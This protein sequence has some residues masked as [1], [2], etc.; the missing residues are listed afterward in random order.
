MQGPRNNY[1]RLPWVI[2]SKILAMLHD[3][4]EY[5]EIRSDR[6][7]AAALQER[8]LKL[9]ATTFLAIKRSQ[10]YRDYVD[11]AKKS[12]NTM[13]AEKITAA[14]LKNFESVDDVS[15]VARYEIS[16]HIKDL[17]SELNYESDPAE[18]SKM[19]RSLTQSLAVISNS[20]ADRKLA[21]KDAEIRK[22]HKLLDVQQKSF[23]D[24]QKR[25]SELESL[26][27]G[28]T[29]DETKLRQI[30]KEKKLL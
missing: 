8:N 6:E 24:L 18:K 28:Q 30:E 16:R 2:R 17:L 19:L 4:A 14:L 23:E 1:S 29:I 25:L 9:H 11:S 13:T 12:Q 10:E 15:E 22:L 27:P 5:D 21:E 26:I 7:V 3:G 20:S